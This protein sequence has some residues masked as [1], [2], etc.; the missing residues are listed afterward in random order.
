MRS[1]YKTY[2][3]IVHVRKID[4]GK[5]LQQEAPPAAA[6]S[7][8]PLGAIARNRDSSRQAEPTVATAAGE[9]RA[10]EAREEYH[11]GNELDAVSD[12]RVAELKAGRDADH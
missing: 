1:I 6:T 11:E 9:A 2:V 7:T 5:R 8:P 12:A 3:D 4:K 10:G